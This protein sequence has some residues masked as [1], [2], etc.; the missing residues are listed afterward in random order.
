M[1]I[2]MDKPAQDLRRAKAT[3]QATIAGAIGTTPPA[4]TSSTPIRGLPQDIVAKAQRRAQAGYNPVGT[5][6]PSAV[7]MRKVVW[8][9]A[10]LAVLDAVLLVVALV[11]GSTVLA[12]VAV[13]LLVVFAGAA[14]VGRRTAARDDLRLTAL[15]RVA[16]ARAGRWTSSQKWVGPIASTPECALIVAAAQAAQR[17]VSSAPWQSGELA[18]SGVPLAVG[19][20]LDQVDANAFELASHRYPTFPGG[21]PGAPLHTP[22]LDDAWEKTLTRVAALTAYADTLDGRLAAED[23]A[24]TQPG[25]VT[26]AQLRADDVDLLA[27]YL[28]PA[29]YDVN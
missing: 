11:S 22:E 9:S 26:D 4:V 15:E 28:S 23:A 14:I 13:V 18:R 12:V 20:E 6:S 27:F 25:Q 7:T 8:P 3:V 16:I 19:P 17:I 5:D 2:S 24:L 29:I 10:A 21:L 1:S